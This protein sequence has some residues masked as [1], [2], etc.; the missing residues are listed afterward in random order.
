MD[1][2]DV[3]PIL[4]PAQL[5]DVLAAAYLAESMDLVQF[6]ADLRDA[7]NAISQHGGDR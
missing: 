5:H 2:Y 1:S 6:D 4:T 7:L 3:P